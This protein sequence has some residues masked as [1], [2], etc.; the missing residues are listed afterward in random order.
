MPLLR[1]PR[2]DELS[3]EDRA[4]L[5]RLAKRRGSTVE[6]L[7]EIWKAQAHWPA[8]LEANMAEA[9]QAFMQ[10]GRLPALTKQAMHVAVSM[11]N[12]CDY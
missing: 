6:T 1:F 5:E 10:I 4:V 12:G 8:L 7:G 9:A 3:P 11:A 2:P